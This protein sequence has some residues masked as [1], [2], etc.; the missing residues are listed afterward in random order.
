[1]SVR[2]VRNLPVD[3]NAFAVFSEKTGNNEYSLR[4]DIERRQ[5][6]A[7]RVRYNFELQQNDCH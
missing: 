7:R 3:F 2:I 4:I 6:M 5:G 1:M